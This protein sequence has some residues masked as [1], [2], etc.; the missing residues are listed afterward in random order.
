MLHKAS[1]ISWKKR[2]RY[3]FL[4]RAHLRR[5]WYVAKDGYEDRE[6]YMRTARMLNAKPSE[7][8]DVA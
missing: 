5:T 8:A 1:T 3:L 4:Y 2:E 7:R 6:T